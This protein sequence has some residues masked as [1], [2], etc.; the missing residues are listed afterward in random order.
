MPASV[1]T[2]GF[3]LIAADSAV[4]WPQ[5]PCSGLASS[6]PY[7]AADS[8]VIGPVSFERATAKQESSGRCSPQ[9]RDEGCLAA[10]CETA[11]IGSEC[12]S[13]GKLVE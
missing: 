5:G 3:V 12:I 4:I 10:S 2:A 8:A 11:L 1:M 9:E 7:L 13:L 6:N